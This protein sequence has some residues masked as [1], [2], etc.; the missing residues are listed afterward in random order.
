MA[1]RSVAGML[2]G[3]RLMAYRMLVAWLNTP[4]AHL[5]PPAPVDPVRL[6]ACLRPGDVILVAGC[7]RFSR[8][9]QHLTGCHWS[10]V[11][12]YTGPVSDADPLLCVVEADVAQGVRAISLAMLG[13]CRLKIVRPVGL[14]DAARARLVAHLLGR[15]GHAYDLQHVID[16]ARHLLPLPA[17]LRGRWRS[18]LPPVLGSGDPTKAICSTLLA[19][20][21]L[22]VGVPIVPSVRA[23]MRQAELPAEAAVQ[24]V[25][26]CTPRDFDTSSVFLPVEDAAGPEAA[27]RGERA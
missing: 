9:V 7:T 15:I 25:T 24:L 17:W 21:F 5:R 1:T 3:M 19:Q 18:R 2:G 4:L 11:A 27:R 10:H 23:P 8:L 26:W 20:A 14:D 13:G 6:V 12:I 22:S 16:L